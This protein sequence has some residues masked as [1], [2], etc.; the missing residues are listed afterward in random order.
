MAQEVFQ[1][2]NRITRDLSDEDVIAE[3]EDDS[4]LQSPGA[5]PVI[6]TARRFGEAAANKHRAVANILYS[7]LLP[8][9][10]YCWGRPSH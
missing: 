1:S 8:A 7:P 5:R 10:N 4:C 6:A 2:I 9:K 3:L